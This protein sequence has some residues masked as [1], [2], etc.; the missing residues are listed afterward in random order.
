MSILLARFTKIICI[1]VL[2]SL[3]ND[4]KVCYI[5]HNCYLAQFKCNYTNT[6]IFYT[7]LTKTSNVIQP[8]E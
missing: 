3:A 2:K 7:D 1:N 6:G 8:C 5:V 4:N